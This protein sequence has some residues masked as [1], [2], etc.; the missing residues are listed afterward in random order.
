MPPPPNTPVPQKLGRRHRFSLAPPEYPLPPG[1]A[2]AFALYSDGFGPAS[3]P[4][5][6]RLLEPDAARAILLASQTVDVLLVVVPL[7]GHRRR[8][9]Q[10]VGFLQDA[11]NHSFVRLTSAQLQRPCSFL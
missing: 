9:A 7:F 5:P 3:L 2:N 4:P 1:E 6:R 11:W 10:L 8:V